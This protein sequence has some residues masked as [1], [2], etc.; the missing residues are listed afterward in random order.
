MTSFE[1]NPYQH[2]TLLNRTLFH[3]SHCFHKLYLDLDL[4]L[5]NLHP[6]VQVLKVCEHSSTPKR[7]VF[8]SKWV[9]M[10][11]FASMVW[12]QPKMFLFGK[13][14]ML[15]SFQ[16]FTMSLTWTQIPKSNRFISSFTIAWQKNFSQRIQFQKCHRCIVSFRMRKLHCNIENWISCLDSLTCQRTTTIS[17]HQIPNENSSV[18]KACNDARIGLWNCKRHCVAWWLPF[19][20][21]SSTLQVINDNEVGWRILKLLGDDTYIRSLMCNCRKRCDEL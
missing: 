19:L 13:F 5:N 1:K 7:Q 6:W 18:F 10:L 15:N 3:H 20:K 21:Q 11:W 9:H 14:P 4:F 8:H 12:K 2:F 16:P 17:S